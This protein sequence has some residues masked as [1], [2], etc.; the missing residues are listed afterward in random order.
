MPSKEDILTKI[1]DAAIFER[2]LQT[3][4]KK[5]ITNPVRNDN[6]PDCTFFQ[7]SSGRIIFID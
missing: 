7:S 4:T 6:H 1:G 2:Y 3:P 5:K